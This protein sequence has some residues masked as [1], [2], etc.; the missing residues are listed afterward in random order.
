LT[1]C[2]YVNG[3]YAPYA[4]AAI[5]AEDR[6]FQFGDGVYE[7]IE[8]R[9]KRLV[10]VTRHLDRLQR[11]LGELM[12]AAPMSRGAMMRVFAE[13]V[14][15]NRVSSGIIYC[16]VTRGAAPRDFA[17]PDKDHP[18]TFVC[19]ARPMDFTRVD[20]RARTGIA[21]KT[22]ADNRWGRCDL[23]T[24]MLLPAVLAKHAAK[25]EGAQDAWFVDRDGF[26]T[27]G[28]SNN[29]WIVTQAGELVTRALGPDILPGVTRATVMDVARQ[30][31]L[32]VIE[33]P[34]TV[35]EAL[36]AREALLTSATTIVMPV[37]QIDGRPVGDGKPGPVAARL[38]ATFHAVAETGGL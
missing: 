4:E 20:A 25:A 8:V 11:S 1:R 27:E 16:Q 31:Q 19:L 12:I 7:V 15:R 14:R 2:I 21:V 30:L 26:V 38:R 3:R 28:A 36:G 13:V 24:V 22:M 18:V 5:H 6:G 17:L 9:G 23:K 37:V 29:A 34:F 35:A 10:D 32:T 33:R